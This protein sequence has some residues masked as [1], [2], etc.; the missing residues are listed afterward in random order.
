MHWHDCPVVNSRK[1]IF[2]KESSRSVSLIWM[3]KKQKT[4]ISKGDQKSYY[5]GKRLNTMSTC[6]VQFSDVF[7]FKDFQNLQIAAIYMIWKKYDQDSIEQRMFNWTSLW[8][9]SKW[10]SD[11]PWCFAVSA[12]CCESN[13][14]LSESQR[15]VLLIYKAK[16]TSGGTL[17]W[18]FSLFSWKTMIQEYKLL[19]VLKI[20]GTGLKRLFN[21]VN[22]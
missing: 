2:L 5:N 7:M 20:R 17:L 4:F 21:R 13:L 15:N 10:F 14:S 1:G 12:C 19:M 16:M 22:H 6:T 9:P 3:S 11:S 8:Y 18:K